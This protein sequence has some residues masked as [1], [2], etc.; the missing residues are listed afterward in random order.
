MSGAFRTGQEV[1]MTLRS[2]WL[3]PIAVVGLTATIL[4]VELF[5][6]VITQPVAAAQFLGAGTGGGWSG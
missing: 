5:W 4:A 6:A 3:V 1:V 2:R